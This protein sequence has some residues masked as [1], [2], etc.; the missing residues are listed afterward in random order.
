VR[1]E[2]VVTATVTA[3][4][5]RIDQQFGTTFAVR[6]YSVDMN[7]ETTRSSEAVPMPAARTFSF[8]PRFGR[9]RVEEN[10]RV[11]GDEAVD[12]VRAFWKKRTP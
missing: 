1:A 12:K 4:E 8:D 2:V 10:A 7:A 9:E 11:L 5:Q 6:T 3:L